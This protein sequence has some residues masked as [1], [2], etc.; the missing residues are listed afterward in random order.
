MENQQPETELTF[1]NSPL[2]N[3]KNI[4][5]DADASAQM[6]L[7]SVSMQAGPKAVSAVNSGG[8]KKE[9]LEVLAKEYLKP[10]RALVI[11]LLPEQGK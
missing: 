8:I 1:S 10:D 4:L 11:G 2:Q 5:S 3:L 6:D 7:T 9:D